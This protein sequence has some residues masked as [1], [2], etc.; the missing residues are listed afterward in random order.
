MVKHIT[1][2]I[3]SVSV[4]EGDKLLLIQE[5][6]G[7]KKGRWNFPTG[8]LKF[9]ES[10]SSGAIREAEE[11]TGYKVSLLGLIGVYTY[12]SPTN[13]HVIRFLMSGRAEAELTLPSREEIAAVHWWTFEEL[14]TLMTDDELWA[15]TV[16]RRMLQDAKRMFW[17][18]LN[19][20]TEFAEP[21]GE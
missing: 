19:V 2:P 9:G 3:V 6:R 11:E 10:L 13:H 8:H 15:P 14:D 20:L 12:I 21:K 16:M 18:P 7:K 17:T 4:M 1:R 5:G